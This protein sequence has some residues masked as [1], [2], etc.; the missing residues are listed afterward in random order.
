MSFGKRNLIL[1]IIVCVAVAVIGVSFAY[2]VSGVNVGGTGSSV[3]LEP[4]DMI[5]VVYDAGSSTLNLENAIPGDS[6]SKTFSVT[7]TPTE[8]ENSVRY[9]IILNLTTNEF[10][11]N[12]IRYTLRDDTGELATSTLTDN[13]T[14]EAVLYTDSRTVAGQTTINY[15]LEV[16]FVETDSDQTVNSNKSLSGSVKVE[17]AG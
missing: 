6:A 5:S 15:T 1:G 12:D 3:E 7:I 2:F 11:N 14:G 13:Q 8:T 9:A 16:E 10:V 4:G 17:F